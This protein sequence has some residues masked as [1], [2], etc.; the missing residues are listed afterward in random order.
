MRATLALNGLIFSEFKQIKLVYTPE[1]I[2]K[3][4]YFVLNHQK[5]SLTIL[6]KLEVN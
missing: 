1:I 2:R 5:V 3:D 6:V 4:S